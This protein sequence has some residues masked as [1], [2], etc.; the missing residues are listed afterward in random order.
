MRTLTGHGKTR[1]R[2]DP[3]GVVINERTQTR[4]PLL[5]TEPKRNPAPFRT[6]TV[7]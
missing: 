5:R 6:T 1:K 7:N 2:A 3:S 4:M